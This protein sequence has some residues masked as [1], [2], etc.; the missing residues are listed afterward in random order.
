MV[1]QLA[2]RKNLGVKKKDHKMLYLGNTALIVAHWKF[3]VLE[4]ARNSF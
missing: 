2:R 4:V 1:F 3:D